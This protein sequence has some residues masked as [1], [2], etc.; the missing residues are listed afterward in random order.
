MKIKLKILLKNP[1]FLTGA[2]LTAVK[3]SS[4]YPDELV[5]GADSVISLKNELIN[6]VTT[7]EITTYKDQKR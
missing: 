1:T 7:K 3:I 4:K 5:L 6:L 2:G